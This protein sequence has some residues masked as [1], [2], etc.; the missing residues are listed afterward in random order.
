[1][2][3][4]PKMESIFSII[5]AFDKIE[6]KFENG[7]VLEVPKKLVIVVTKLLLCYLIVKVSITRLLLLQS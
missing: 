7:V 4:L 1:M 5:G 6:Y 2:S 3:L